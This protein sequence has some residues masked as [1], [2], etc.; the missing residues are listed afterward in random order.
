MKLPVPAKCTKKAN[1]A[2][3][4][5][6]HRTGEMITTLRCNTG[7]VRDHFAAAFLHVL[8][9][10]ARDA[11]RIFVLNNQMLH[12]PRSEC[13]GHLWPGNQ[14]FLKIGSHVLRSDHF[15]IVQRKRDKNLRRGSCR[16][17]QSS[18]VSKGRLRIP[19]KMSA[20]P[21]RVIIGKSTG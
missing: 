1:V 13:Q 3:I 7:A 21:D 5:K 18:E 9:L 15:N 17:L 10:F 16:R 2:E 12:L 20:K 11:H 8:T 4:Q 14:D 6:T 19:G